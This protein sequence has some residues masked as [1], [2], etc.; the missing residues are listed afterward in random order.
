MEQAIRHED[1]TMISSGEWAA[2]KATARLVKMDL[3]SLPLPRDRR[4]KGHKKTKTYFR[5]FHRM[6]WD[7]AIEK[8]ESQQPLLALC[9]AHWKA[10]HVLGNTLLVPVTV[11][12][13]DWDDTDNDGDEL[14]ATS[15]SA[16]PVKSTDA[17]KLKRSAD[18]QP[19][20]AKKAKTGKDTGRTKVV[21]DASLSGSEH[22]TSLSNYAY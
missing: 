2:I 21:T 3:L 13:R 20:K 10:D 15:E 19:H 4:A 18:R 12:T 7:A 6:Q 8:M 9:A 5:T 11:S 17:K 16:R 14:D 22:G 1:G